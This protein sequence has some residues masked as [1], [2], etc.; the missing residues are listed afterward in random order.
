MQEKS[1]QNFPFNTQVQEKSDENGSWFLAKILIV[2]LFRLVSGESRIGDILQSDISHLQLNTL[3]NG[4]ALFMAER[5]SESVP[6]SKFM[7]PLE[8]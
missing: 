2:L 3:L 1:R 8:K 5:D 4:S 7:V 6:P